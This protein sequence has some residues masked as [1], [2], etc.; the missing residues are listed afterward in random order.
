[1]SYD[2]TDLSNIRELDRFQLTPGSQSIVH[3]T[4]ILNDYAVTSW[5]K[6]GFSIADVSRPDNII[7]VGRYDTYA[8]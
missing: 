5:Y 7:P 2:I 4:H 1:A 3:N 6:D 8:Q